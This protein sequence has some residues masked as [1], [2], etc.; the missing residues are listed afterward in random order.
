MVH[1]HS[2][3]ASG[4][5]MWLII[6]QSVPGWT[7]WR[8]KMETFSALLALCG[9][10]WLPLTKASDAEP[11]CFLWSSHQL[12]VGFTIVRLV[13]WGAI[14]VIMAPMQWDIGWRALQLFTSGLQSLYDWNPRRR[15]LCLELCSNRWNHLYIISS[16]PWLLI[17]KM[18]SIY[19]ESDVMPICI[20]FNGWRQ[21]PETWENRY[22][23]PRGNAV[24]QTNSRG[25][26]DN[27]R[28]C[29]Q[30]LIAIIIRAQSLWCIK[31]CR[32]SIKRSSFCFSK[33][34]AVPTTIHTP[35][36]ITNVET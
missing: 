24:A 6:S 14:V 34:F 27:T 5:D 1:H 18:T 13:I 17:A 29:W 36:N 4:Y 21:S 10:W 35:S 2:H 11:W 26:I 33:I 3:P 20:M 19:V 31:R 12:T 7:W 16:K 9:D 22:G 28:F 25:L 8:H 32:I 30:G 15:K 23:A